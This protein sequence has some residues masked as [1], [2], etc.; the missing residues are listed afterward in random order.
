[1]PGIIPLLILLLFPYT[2]M[3]QQ[4]ACVVDAKSGGAC[5]VVPDE[6][7]DAVWLSVR[8]LERG[9]AVE[10]RV[11]SFYNTSE[12][13]HRDRSTDANGIA[14][15]P[16]LFPELT[17]PTAI[18][19]ETTVNGHA[20]EVSFKVSPRPEDTPPEI[21][22]PAAIASWYESRQIPQPIFFE[23]DNVTDPAACRSTKVRATAEDAG[24]VTPETGYAQWAKTDP[25]QK[26]AGRD[27]GGT[28]CYYRA[29]WK[30]GPTVGEQFL[31]ARLTTDTSS[32]VQAQAR[33]HKLPSLFIGVAIGLESE[34]QTVETR[35]GRVSVERNLADGGGTVTYDSAF[36][37]KSIGE[38]SGGFRSRPIIGIDWPLALG[39]GALRGSA[40]VA[41][42]NPDRDWYLG[43]SLMTL[44]P[45]FLGGRGV[46]QAAIGF[47]LQGFAHISKREV[48]LEAD[49]GI[50][51]AS[52][53]EE[54]KYF[55]RPAVAVSIDGTS[56]LDTFKGLFAF[57]L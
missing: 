2:L 12:G 7:S 1:M 3:A 48:L 18:T 44:W 52:C 5:K 16:L 39:L 6:K 11:V 34:Y 21:Q 20:V 23:I 49:C 15:L 17:K 19:A 42:D 29:Y 45:K 35:E 37:V 46:N 38:E 14:T 8:I 54:T 26:A 30:L 32:F 41:L 43:I 50:D 57:A 28:P 27:S 13:L 25:E 56:L 10:D 55:L 47:N 24:S 31:T 4:A 22:A 9:I 36:V 40:G 51:P 33:S 53:K